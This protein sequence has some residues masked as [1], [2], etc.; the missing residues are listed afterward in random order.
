M[1]LQEFRERW[2]KEVRERERNSQAGRDAENHNRNPK[3]S[4]GTLDKPNGDSRNTDTFQ[5]REGHQESSGAHSSA[6]QATSQQSSVS[7]NKYAE[8]LFQE[9]G[10]VTINAEQ[11]NRIGGSGFSDNSKQSLV[12]KCGVPGNSIASGPAHLNEDAGSGCSCRLRLN[13]GGSSFSGSGSGSESDV[14]RGSSNLKAASETPRLSEESQSG[15]SLRTCHNQQVGS[16]EQPEYIS[17]A[18]SLLEGRT[19]P[20]RDRIEVE[21]LARKKRHAENLAGLSTPRPVHQL[22]QQPLCK[23][24]K[25]EALVDQLIQ[26]LNEI[27][28]IPFF[29]VEL[30]YELA[31]K[32]FQY[33]DRRE[34]GRCAQVSKVWK[35]LAEDEVLWYR[36]CLKEGHLAGASVSDSPCWKGTLRDCRQMQDMLRSNWKNRVGEVR[37]LQYELG[38]VLCDASSSNGLVIAGYTS[39]DVRLWDTLDWDSS[40]SYLQPSHIAVEAVLRPHVTHVRV[41]GAVAVA[42]YE[43]GIVDVWS[44][45][46]GREPVHHYQHLQRVQGLALG[47]EGAI[48]ATASGTQVRVEHPTDK[49]YWET[50]S[51]C[52]LQKPVEFVQLLPQTDG[53]L[54]AVAA[55]ADT[56]YLLRPGQE[57]GVLHCVY[58]HP[59][60]CLDTSSSLAAVGVKSHGWT[61]NAGNKIQVY[62]LQT[63]QAVVD[64]GN[65]AG[66]FTCVNLKDSPPNLLVSGN[67]DRRVRVFD[68]RTGKSVVSLYAHHLGVSAVQTDDWKIVSGGEEGLLCLWEMRMG[69]KLWEMHNRHPVRHARFNT[70]TLVTANIPDEKTPRGAC[71]TDDDL[72]A[73]RRHRGVIFMYDFSVDTSASDHVLPICKSSYTES[74]GYNYNIGLAVPY[75]KLLAEPGSAL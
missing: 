57:H 67:K 36:L 6:L 50:A 49:G 12:C 10:S 74:T 31:L 63:G 11:T 8:K 48:V 54:L 9:T 56:V 69:A 41:N 5:N 52:E 42:A 59:V 47:A 53:G 55:A 35:V 22:Q 15:T 16:E 17:I 14:Q 70:H 46:A 34:L 3:T 23:V 61:M 2:K 60:T 21:R 4:D 58:G 45:E 51:Q 40:A 65:S 30:P 29:D 64:L 19:S 43:D 72:T 32:I 68:L 7:D 62:C 28:E 44:T 75:D 37:Q 26:D 1:D 39:G 24:H 38:K 13:R 27:N 73:H 18:E 25:K 71:I 20:L 33:L 66:D